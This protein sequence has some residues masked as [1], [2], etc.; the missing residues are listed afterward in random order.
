MTSS[1]LDARICVSTVNYGCSELILRALPALLAELERFAEGVVFI[2]DNASPDDD[3]DKLE[4]GLAAM[5]APE[6]VRLIRS[7]RNG[8][9][10][11]G[12]NIAFEAARA[13]PWTPEGVLLLN[14]DAEVRPGAIEEIV[15]VLRSRPKI[16]VVGARL[17]NEVGVSR[18]S[19]YRFPS[20]MREFAGALGIGAVARLWPV[21]IDETDVPVRCDW[22]TGACMMIRQE[23]LDTLGPLDEGYFLYFEEVDYQLQATRAGWEIWHAPQAQVMHLAGAATGIV[24]ST[25]KRGRMPDYWFDSWRRYF[26]KNHGGAYASFAAAMRLTGGALGRLQRRLR[27]KPDESV[28]GFAAS[29]RRR[30][31][32]NLA[33]G[34]RA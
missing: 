4:A 24:G 16:G 21:L 7:P 1:P 8:G 11:A 26:E 6:A 29:F 27:G 17:E 32:M 10:A 18:M 13:L 23:V 2:V 5:G 15:R 22:V 3:A 31:L 25:P 30:C 9:F 34:P 12:N 19:A 14:P 20:A 33:P 28:P